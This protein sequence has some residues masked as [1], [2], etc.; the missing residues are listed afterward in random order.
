MSAL[1]CLYSD[2]PKKIT[3]RIRRKGESERPNTVTAVIMITDAMG[4]VF[5]DKILCIFL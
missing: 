5:F 1:D 4:A 2:V 3:A